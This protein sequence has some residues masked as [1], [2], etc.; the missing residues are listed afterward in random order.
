MI[1]SVS[2]YLCRL[3]SSAELL[4]HVN[5]EDITKIYNLV[6]EEVKPIV[7][8]LVNDAKRWA[9]LIKRYQKAM[10]DCPLDAE[11]L[12]EYKSYNNM[13]KEAQTQYVA[14]TK[15]LLSAVRRD[16]VEE[17]DEFQAYLE[18]HGMA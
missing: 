14:I 18:E 15:V 7:E 1:Y 12:K 9:K 8:P 10:D 17:Q 3:Y 16:A 6:R 4:Y 2:V 5:M 11:H 13:L